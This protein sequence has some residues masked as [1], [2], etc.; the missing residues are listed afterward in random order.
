MPTIT[1]Y[2]DIELDTDD[3]LTEIDDDTLI[4]ELESRSVDFAL[5]EK[6]AEYH[7]L[8]KIFYS[9]DD[10]YRHLCDICETGYHEPIDSILQKLKDKLV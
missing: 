6:S 10:L 9:K 5:T 1:I 4:E 3:I 8:K 2:T 7:I